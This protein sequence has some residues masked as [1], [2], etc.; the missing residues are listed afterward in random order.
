MKKTLFT[1]ALASALFSMAS[2]QASTESFT[3][4]VGSTKTDWSQLISLT[5]FDTNL[6]TL[7]SVTFGVSGSMTGSD[8]FTNNNSNSA[9]ISATVGSLLTISKVG[10]NF[11]QGQFITQANP[12]FK[13]Q[14]F[15]L[16]SGQSYTIGPLTTSDAKTRALTD[17]ANLSLYSQAGAGSFNLNMSGYADSIVQ[18]PGNVTS[19]VATYDNGDATVTYDY[20]AVSPVPE[21]ETYAMLLAG[22]GL[23]GFM[24]RRRKCA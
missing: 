11:V 18:G 5:K 1:I 23:M 14:S 20:T 4:H 9:W 15:N 2:A 17:A 3:A 6:G 21:P 7:N 22:L 10:D 19:T 12:L 24:S 8:T 13:K 16:D